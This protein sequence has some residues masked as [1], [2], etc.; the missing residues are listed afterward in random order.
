MRVPKLLACFVLWSLL[1]LPVLAQQSSATTNPTTNDPQAIA[2]LQKSLAA[3]TGGTPVSDV[4]L[5]GTAERISGSDDETGTATLEAKGTQESKIAL[6][7]SSST[8]TEVRNASDGAPEGSYAGSDATVQALA[9]HNCFTDPA[10]F[11]PP[12]SSIA[13]S[14]SNTATNIS[15]VG[16]ETLD[17]TKVQH[18]RLWLSVTSQ[19][20]A[21][22]NLIAHLSTVDWYLNAESFLPVAEKFT[23]HPPGNASVDIPVE[24]LFSNYQQIGSVWVPFRVQKFQNGTLSLD[25]DISSANLNSGLSDS[26]FTME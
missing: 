26:E 20:A 13:A 11:F 3:L 22:V 9:Q 15:Y 23:T 16:A 12:L 25:L 24:I 8:Y 7:L 17:G 2:L 18:V 19:D 6:S 21:A 10:W 5:T 14:L 1:S 4:T